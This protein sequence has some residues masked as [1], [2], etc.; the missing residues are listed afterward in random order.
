M[1][2]KEAKNYKE[3][4]TLQHRHQMPVYN[5]QNHRPNPVINHFPEND[6]SF[7][8]QITIL[9][10]SKY[11]DAV[12]N[13]NETFIVGASMVKGI[14][15]KEVNSK[16]RNSFAKLRFFLGAI[17]K[18]LKYYIVFSLIDEIPDR[19]ILHGGRNDANNKN[20][21]PEKI[22]N[23]IA[24][25][26]MLCRD[27]V[28]NDIFI[29]AMICRRVKFLNKKVKRVNFLLKHICEE[30]GYFFIDN[31]NIEIRDLWKD[32]IHLLESCKTKLAENFTENNVLKNVRLKN[33][34]KVIIS[35]IDI[36]S[37]RNN[38]E[39]LTEIVRDKVDLLMIFE[40]KLDSSFPN[41]QF[42]MKYYSKPYRFDRNSK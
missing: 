29:S 25:M 2:G 9:G 32:G 13:G 6:N 37:L 5:K 42:Y 1:L 10:N 34:N 21:T 27:Y 36:N 20:S 4:Q 19:I 40:T 38:F 16:L 12:R 31:S 14:R 15:M 11:S 23:E 28:V 24:H 3:R 18:H 33:S 41:A 7:L 17:L 22:A 35:H 8:Q 30:N 26:A 39:L